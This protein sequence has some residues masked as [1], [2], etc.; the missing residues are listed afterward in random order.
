[1]I[2]K[3]KQTARNFFDLYSNLRWILGNEAGLK[4]IV[5]VFGYILAAMFEVVFLVLVYLLISQ[6]VN[7]G[8]QINIFP[9]LGHYNLTLHG[10]LLLLILTL[11]TKNLALIFLKYY[12]TRVFA[13]RESNISTTFIQKSLFEKRDS[14]KGKNS[15]DLLQLFTSIVPAVFTTVLNP[16]TSFLADTFSLIFILYSAFTLVTFNIIWIIAYLAFFAIAIAL[17]IGRIAKNI[18]REGADLGKQSLKKFLEFNKMR[19]EIVLSHNEDFFIRGVQSQQREF[20]K[21]KSSIIIL[22]VLPRYLLEFFLVFGFVVLIAVENLEAQGVGNIASIGIIVGIGFRI[23]PPINSM[24]SNYSSIMSGLPYISI[25]ISMSRRFKGMEDLTPKFPTRNFGKILYSGRLVVKDLGYT[26]PGAQKP[27][28]N[29]QNLLI[30]ENTTLLIKGPS[31]TGKTTF[32]GLISGFLNPTK[33]EVY[34][35]EGNKR[36]SIDEKLT[37]IS[38]LDQEIPLLDAS[39]AFNI[40]LKTPSDSEMQKIIRVAEQAG[41]L[42]RILSS[43]NSFNS[44]IGENGSQ[45]SA[46]ERQ[47]LGLARSLYREP[48]L[49]ILDEPTANLD[50]KTEAIIWKTLLALKNSLTIIIISHK[51]VPVN[52]YDDSA[53]F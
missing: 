48:R 31:G 12:S 1:M 7:S 42:D 17:P 5:I 51:P 10:I 34:L 44:L 30:P 11:L 15:A 53:T 46:G 14:F 4:F 23:L 3:I 22:S 35:Q 27:V 41:I 16:M 2:E 8:E 49:L 25:L 37:G 32:V 21:L 47:R 39:F 43:E 28:L 13:N 45:L 40:A 20:L 9:F 38:Y 18:N 50:E 52:V 33:G 26:Y 24:V 6:L 36:I 19:D 29:G